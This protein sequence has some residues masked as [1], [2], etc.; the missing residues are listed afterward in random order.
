MVII[1]IKVNAMLTV[2]NQH[3]VEHLQFGRVVV[4]VVVRVIDE[5]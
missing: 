2:R 1:N 4:R 5:G 3:C